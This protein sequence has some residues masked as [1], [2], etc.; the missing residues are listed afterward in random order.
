M[1]QVLAIIESIIQAILLTVKIISMVSRIFGIKQKESFKNIMV[2][3]E[4]PFHCLLKNVNF[5]LTMAAQNN[6]LKLC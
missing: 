1:L 3:T 4:M 5:D 2:L 6:S